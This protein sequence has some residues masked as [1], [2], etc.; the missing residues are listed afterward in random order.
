[1]ITAAEKQIKNSNLIRKDVDFSAILVVYKSKEGYWKGFAH[2]YDVTSQADSKDEALKK[3][4]ELV[5]IYE[6]ELKEFGYPSHLRHQ[7]LSFEED[8]EIFNMV[9]LDAINK[10][11]FDSPT[12]H[13]ETHKIH[14]E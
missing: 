9:A 8:R 11:K 14:A 3:L 6:D 7:P 13:V 12:C 1:M 4:K 5:K 10:E 2:P